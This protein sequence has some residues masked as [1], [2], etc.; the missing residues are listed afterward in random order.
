[1][2]LAGCEPALRSCEQIMHD[3][4]TRWNNYARRRNKRHHR[5]GLIR[6]PPMRISVP[7]EKNK[8]KFSKLSNPDSFPARREGS[9]EPA[10]DPHRRRASSTL[11][12]G[13]FMGG[14]D[15]PLT[16]LVRTPN[17]STRCA[18][19]PWS[20]RSGIITRCGV[21]S[22]PICFTNLCF[23][24]FGGRKKKRREPSQRCS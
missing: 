9:N 5:Q 2:R 18:T 15:L 8:S 16:R 17:K 11:I 4:Q 1:M 23:L 7:R 24:C 10:H 20:H 3:S 14:A 19:P 21:M 6:F 22:F 13:C 12:L